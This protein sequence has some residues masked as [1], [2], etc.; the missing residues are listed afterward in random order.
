VRD[1]LT[2][3]QAVQVLQTN[4]RVVLSEDEIRALSVKLPHRPPPRSFVGREVLAQLAQSCVGGDGH[5]VRREAEGVARVVESVLRQLVAEL[6][7]QDRIILRLHC[8]EGFSWTDI[9]RFL[10][11]PQRALYDRKDKLLKGMQTELRR[12]GLHADVL[13]LLR[14]ADWD[15]LVSLE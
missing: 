8:E 12:R 2:L 5:I 4:H 6:P 13:G 1:G 11:I 3:D 10:Q 15:I 7:P 9:S 14:D